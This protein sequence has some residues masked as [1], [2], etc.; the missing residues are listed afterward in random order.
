M[1]IWSTGNFR[2][3]QIMHHPMIISISFSAV[4]LHTAQQLW[5]I[6]K[7]CKFWKIDVLLN[8][9]LCKCTYVNNVFTFYDHDPWIIT[10]SFVFQCGMVWRGSEENM[11]SNNHFRRGQSKVYYASDVWDPGEEELARTSFRSSCSDQEHNIGLPNI[12]HHNR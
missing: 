10:C 3:V 2:I 5:L 1:C 8:E 4:S 11:T 9:I 6:G 7:V 12:E